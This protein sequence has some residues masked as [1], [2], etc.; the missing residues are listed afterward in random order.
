MSKNNVQYFFR[1]TLFRLSLDNLNALEVTDAS[2]DNNTMELCLLK[3]QKK[4]Y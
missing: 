2:A 4:V 3:G 1:D